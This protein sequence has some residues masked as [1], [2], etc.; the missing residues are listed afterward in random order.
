M[1]FNSI[2]KK[3]V[4]EQGRYEILKKTYTEPKKKGDKVKPA[5]M[6]IEELNAEKHNFK[7]RAEEND[8]RL[9]ASSS[10][11]LDYCWDMIDDINKELRE[12]G[13]LV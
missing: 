10:A 3:L 7:K 12:R 9:T 8:G 2:I 5:K 6:S 11:D 1:K 13:K 4:V